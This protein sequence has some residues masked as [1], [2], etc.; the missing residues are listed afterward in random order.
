MP[1]K[2]QSAKDIEISSPHP[3]SF[4]QG[5]HIAEVLNDPGSLIGVPKAWEKEIAAI[6]KITISDENGIH[7]DT[8]PSL[9]PTTDKIE[10]AKKKKSRKKKINK[11]NVEISYP[12]NFHQPIHVDF[13]SDTGFT[14][15]PKEWEALL[16]SSDISK[17]EVLA[18]HQDVIKVLEFHDKRFNGPHPPGEKSPAGGSPE[19]NE[20]PPPSE[21]AKQEAPEP[22]PEDSPQPKVR[23][24]RKKKKAEGDEM[25]WID[26]GDP[27]TLYINLEKCGEGSSGEVFKGIH[28]ETGETV[29]IKIISLG[30]EE[31][32]SNIRNEIMMMK[33]SKHPNVVDH[34][35]TYLKDEKLWVVMEYMDGGALTEVISICQI[36]EP[37]IACICKEILKALVAIHEGDRIHRDIKSDNVLITM[38]GDIKLADF[39]YCAQLTESVQ[40]R[41]SVVG[42]PYWMAPELIKGMKYGTSVD[43]WSMGIAAIEMAEGDPPYLDFP[44]LRALFLIAT[45]GAPSLKDPDNWSNTFKN[46]LGKC[47]E[48]EPSERATAKQLLEHPFLKLACPT[49]TLTPLIVKAK[50]VAAQLSSGSDYSSDEDY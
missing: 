13:N 41:S 37:Q 40:Q 23:K 32:L 6:N 29:A 24:D 15:L 31:K 5:V 38:K 39:G 35:G 34:R 9:V 47:L 28:K 7:D 17:E 26:E 16:K 19:R 43:I 22:E 18:N 42:T 33:L 45:H 21:E 12:R 27:T 3:G 2:K 48:L 8:P 25:D 14:G 11:Q 30:G 1:K 4:R 44:P 20:S 46:F 50:E 10:P 49:S 36:S